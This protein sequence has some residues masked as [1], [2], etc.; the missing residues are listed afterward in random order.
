MDIQTVFKRVEIKYLITR[1]QEETI[2]SAMRAYMLPDRYGPCV[3]RN[4][5]YD[6]EN[7]RLIRRSLEK[8]VYK[9]KLRLRSYGQAGLDDIVFVELKKK[10]E[11]VVYK[12]RLRL[13]QGRAREWLDGGMYP[14]RP[15]SQIAREIDYFRQF[16]EDLRPAAFISYEREAFFAADGSDFRI[17][18]DQNILAR[19]DKLSLAEAPGGMSLLSPGKILMELKSSSAIPLWLAKLLSREGIFKSS[20][21]KYGTAYVNLIGGC[22]SIRSSDK[23]EGQYANF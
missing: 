21:S 23:G 9:E 4:I 5:Y 11:S 18:F 15:P 6:T 10:Y 19:L 13:P 8:P 2:R 12:R 7:Y 17:T 1:K 3:I 20:F 16:Y 14:E 22:S